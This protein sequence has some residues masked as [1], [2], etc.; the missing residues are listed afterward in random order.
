MESRW[1]HQ[2]AARK[3][4]KIGHRTV[5][6]VLS[7]I[8]FFALISCEDLETEDPTPTPTPVDEGGYYGGSPLDPEEIEKLVIQLTNEERIEAGLE[9]L[10]HNPLLSEIG[11]GHSEQMAEFDHLTHVLQS[12]SPSNRASKAGYDCDLSENI[13]RHPRLREYEYGGSTLFFTPFMSSDYV[14]PDFRPKYWVADDEEM[15]RLLV[16]GWMFSPGH[17]KN[18]LDAEIREFGVGVFIAEDS[19]GKYLDEVAW[20]TQNFSRCE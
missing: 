7:L 11:R 8:A 13:F 20:A 19:L 6:V 10:K 14:P 9:P 4:Q 15:A 17:R 18:I 5:P 16:R 2:Q 3:E 1:E 12:L